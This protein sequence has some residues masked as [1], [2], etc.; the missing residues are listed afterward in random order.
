MREFTVFTSAKRNFKK[1]KFDK[2]VLQTD[3]FTQ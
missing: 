2:I 3:K 1:P